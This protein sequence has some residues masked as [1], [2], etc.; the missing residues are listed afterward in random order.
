MLPSLRAYKASA[1]IGSGSYGL[2]FDCT[3]FST[4][5]DEVTLVQRPVAVKTFA[6]ANEASAEDDELEIEDD[7]HALVRELTS[8]AQLRD[9]GRWSV[10]ILPGTLPPS[11]HALDNE[12]ILVMPRAQMSLGHCVRSAGGR[13]FPFC[14]TLHILKSCLEDL[15]VLQ[16][17]GI[18]HRDVKLENI[19]I[20]FAEDGASLPEVKVI[21]WGL[22]TRQGWSTDK[23]IVT[24]PYRAPEVLQQ[25]PHSSFKLDVWALGITLI[26]TCIGGPLINEHHSKTACLQKIDA[27]LSSGLIDGLYQTHIV[28]HPD[29][30]PQVLSFRSLLKKMLLKDMGHR[31]SLEGVANHALWAL[32]APKI[33]DKWW[34]S[35]MAS[36]SA[37]KRL[38]VSEENLTRQHRELYK[39]WLSGSAHYKTVLA[40]AAGSSPSLPSSAAAGGG[41]GGGSDTSTTSTSP[42]LKL[43]REATVEE[44]GITIPLRVQTLLSFMRAFFSCSH[45]T[46]QTPLYALDIL[47]AVFSKLEHDVTIEDALCLASGAF[48]I[49]CS[50]TCGMGASPSIALIKYL[51]AKDS[52]TVDICNAV[53]RILRHL[54]CSLPPDSLVQATRSQATRSLSKAGANEQIRAFVSKWACDGAPAPAATPSTDAWDGWLM[55]VMPWSK[56][57]WDTAMHVW[58]TQNASALAR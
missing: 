29:E 17:K 49:S 56:R 47:D 10:E 13:T 52:S 55:A 25:L 54:N 20:T 9:E 57:L 33:F 58:V 43:F 3:E 5:K 26:E 16:R 24:L 8:A 6:M 15:L 23:N 53:S 7:L 36:R 50:L 35:Q 38:E 32:P 41:G 51:I 12:W 37:K 48:F 14:V 31:I 4:E 34:L 21:D 39:R 18:S 19:L 1:C 40:F 46:L 2:V 42:A 11:P 22:S 27:F 30:E 45:M 28:E 44:S